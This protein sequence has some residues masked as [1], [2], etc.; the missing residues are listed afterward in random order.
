MEMNEGMCVFQFGFSYSLLGITF[1]SCFLNI[2]K[3][4]PSRDAS[5][6]PHRFQ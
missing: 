3:T 4:L 2:I 1:L 6:N 5:N